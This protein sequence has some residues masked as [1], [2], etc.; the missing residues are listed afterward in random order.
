MGPDPNVLFT[1][2]PWGPWWGST[3]GIAIYM[4]SFTI[5]KS[6]DHLHTYGSRAEVTILAQAVGVAADGQTSSLSRPPHSFEQ[7]RFQYCRTVP[8]VAHQVRNDRDQ[9]RSHSLRQFTTA[10]MSHEPLQVCR[11]NKLPWSDHLGSGGRSCT[12]AV[13]AWRDA[14]LSDLLGSMSWRAPFEPHPHQGG[15]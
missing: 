4:E 1:A 7:P 12:E 9:P 13:S 10:H 8:C 6:P 11:E 14:N 5:Q 3:Q 15:S 2:L